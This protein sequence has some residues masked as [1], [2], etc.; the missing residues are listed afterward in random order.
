MKYLFL[1]MTLYAGSLIAATEEEHTIHW[2][3]SLGGV[4]KRADVKLTDGTFP[5]YIT[6]EYIIEVDRA[7]KWYEGIGQSLHYAHVH[8][9]RKPM[10][11]LIVFD[12]K[13]QK[14]VDR[15]ISLG[16]SICPKIKVVIIKGIQ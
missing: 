6:D 1:L 16:N 5:D 8:G 3:E 10:L 13:D 4:Y 15:A 14:F 2:C 7:H 9:D 12:E 11:A